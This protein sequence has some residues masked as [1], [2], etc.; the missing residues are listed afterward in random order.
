VGL[1]GHARGEP[2]QIGYLIGAR[3]VT[4]PAEDFRVG[5][6]LQVTASHIW[7]DEALGSFTC[8]IERGAREVAQGT[9]NVYRGD[10]ERMPAP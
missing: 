4:L 1:R 2:V 10:V 6:A 5:D 8:A 7:G 9:L 3:D